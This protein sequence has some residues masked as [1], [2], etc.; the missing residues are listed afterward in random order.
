[1]KGSSSTAASVSSRPWAALVVLCLSLLIVTLDATILNV[2]LPTLVTKSHA[3]SSDLQWIVDAYVL[4]FA[5]LMLVAGSLADWIGRKRTFLAGS[6]RRSQRARSWAAVSGLGRDADRGRASMGV[7]AA[8][9]HALDAGRSLRTRSPIEHERQPR[10]RV[11]GRHQRRRDRTRTDRRRSP[12]GSLRMGLG[13]PHQRTDR[14][15]PG[16][17][18]RW[19]SS[20]IPRTQPPGA[21][22]SSARRSSIAGLGLVLYGI[23]EAPIHPAGVHRP[24]VLVHPRHR[25][26]SRSWPASCRMGAAVPSTRCST[27]ASS[28]S[29]ASRA[30]SFRSL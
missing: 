12:A 2:A 18:S 24:R 25:R 20:P 4:L 23:I 26:H 29:A 1:M 30:R 16:S 6:G 28:P 14:R 15:G 3:S 27:F 5:C 21:P 22:T 8:F 19:H 7:G 11:L 17:C 9:D 13:V 10:D